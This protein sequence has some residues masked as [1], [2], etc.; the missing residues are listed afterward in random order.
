M[1]FYHFSPPP[2]W[3]C[4]CC[5]CRYRLWSSQYDDAQ[6]QMKFNV[7]LYPFKVQGQCLVLLQSD[8]LKNAEHYS[9]FAFLLLLLKHEFRPLRQSPKGTVIWEFG[10]FGYTK[11]KWSAMGCWS[12]WCVCYS[13]LRKSIA[14]SFLW[15]VIKV[16]N[17]FLFGFLYSFTY[18]SFQ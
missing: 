6:I 3:R 9:Q 16:S 13:C 14:K 4:C 7:I 1:H 8:V 12:R 17:F 18:S 2:L 11:L 10:L 5:Y 15:A